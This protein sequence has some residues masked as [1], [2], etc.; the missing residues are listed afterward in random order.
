MRIW[1]PLTKALRSKPDREE[2]PSQSLKTERCRPDKELVLWKLVQ[3]LTSQHRRLSG[4]RQNGSFQAT[5]YAWSTNQPYLRL[6]EHDAIPSLDAM[7]AFAALSNPLSFQVHGLLRNF[8]YLKLINCKYGLVLRAI[9]LDIS[10][11]CAIYQQMITIFDTNYIIEITTSFDTNY[12]IQYQTK[13][14][15]IAVRIWHNTFM[16]FLAL[17][18]NCKTSFT[19]K[20]WKK[21]FRPKSFGLLRFESGKKATAAV[22]ISLVRAWLTQQNTRMLR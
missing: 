14:T 19:N 6:L 8:T 10:M 12:I 3:P 18:V 2:N 1:K 15:K 21:T 22:H 7:L 5:I 9:Y 20:T 17:T 16:N 11:W 4:R 13:N